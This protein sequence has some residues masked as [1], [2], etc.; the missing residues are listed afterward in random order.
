[1]AVSPFEVLYFDDVLDVCLIPKNCSS[2]LKIMWSHLNGVESRK[3]DSDWYDLS[4]QNYMCY[5]K[6]RNV[7]RITIKRDPIKRYLSAV[8]FCISF[9]EFLKDKW[10][11]IPKSN[12]L[13]GF[14]TGWTE[15][16]LEKIIDGSKQKTYRHEFR[17]QYECGGDLSQYDKVF[18]FEN[19]EECV[20]FIENEIDCE[21]DRV[22]ATVSK[23]IWTEKDLTLQMVADIQKIYKKDYDNGWC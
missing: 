6:F 2:S 11:K 17:S 23:P 22:K 8:N 15:W 14:M 20:T 9:S 13:E 18:D 19:F 5:N 16:D 12:N 1:M 21:L 7:K 3:I 10:Y 4:T